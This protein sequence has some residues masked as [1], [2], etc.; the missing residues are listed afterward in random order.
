L[1]SLNDYIARYAVVTICVFL[2]PKP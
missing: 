2:S 1:F